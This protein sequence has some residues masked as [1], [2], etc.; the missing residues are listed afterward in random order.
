MTTRL[1]RPPFVPGE[2]MGVLGA[3]PC[4][5]QREIVEGVRAPAPLPKNL[6]RDKLEELGTRRFQNDIPVNGTRQR[7]QRH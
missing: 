4:S 5:S 1:S 6:L 2:P 3:D 7:S